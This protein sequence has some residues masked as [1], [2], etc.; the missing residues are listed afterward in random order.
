MTPH[1][2]REG[3]TQDEREAVAGFDHSI[4]FYR[5]QL[6]KASLNRRRIVN[7]AH[8]RAKRRA[9]ANRAECS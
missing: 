5:E 8:Q 2:W 7:R 4:A 9:E 1:L 3:A 6:N